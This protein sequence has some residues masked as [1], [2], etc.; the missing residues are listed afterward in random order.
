MKKV[1]YIL[2]CFLFPVVFSCREQIE[3]PDT[4]GAKAPEL[5]LVSPADGAE[6]IKGTKLD[7]VLT[8]D[9]NVMCPTSQQSRIGIDNG[10]SI[11]KVN[12]YMKDV[13]VSL[14]GLKEES[15]YT[16]SFPEGTIK[17]YNENVAEEIVVRFS[18]AG[19]AGPVEQD[20]DRQLV[21][22]N[23]IL[24]ASKLYDFLLSVY[25]KK[26]IS[27]AIA[28]V[29]WNTDE[30]DW[31]AKWTGKYPA[32][33]VFDYIHLQ[34]SPSNWIDYGD[35]SP[36]LRHFEK[37]GIIGACWH[38]NVPAKEGSSDY[39]CTPGDGSK[40]SDGNWTTTFSA[41]RA[42][43]EGTWENT[44]VKADLEKIADYLLLLQERNIPVIWRPLHEAAGNTYTQWHSGA[45][46]WWGRDG[47]ESYVRL[48]RYMFDF[49]KGKGLR[50][51][52]WVWTT[53]TSGADDC[54]W[55]F[56]PGDEYVD[57][58]GKD[59][60]NNTDSRD[61]S[62]QFKTVCGLS[63][64]KMVALSENGGVADM[65]AQWAAGAKWLFFMPWYDYGNNYSKDYPH[66]HADINWWNAS[67]ASSAVLSLEHIMPDLYE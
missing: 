67:Y 43:Q 18:T 7:V 16:L 37:G 15:T 36:V 66:G 14:S 53:Q 23:P 50:N 32:M 26:T 49:F 9:V 52:I 40:N 20:I 51:L 22:E 62:S 48:W 64:R 46:F 28:K 35:I 5:V 57:I 4:P 61:I 60:Y 30:A 65:A 10:A 59:I 13:T 19:P 11:D 27:G 12:A 31:I 3:N 1:F 54:D 39:T 2:A 38:W 29:D 41:A 47:A 58:V 33:A 17:G 21:T 63:P 55:D 25:G 24:N 45:W 6:N 42:M 8:F 56:Y 44:V 34:S